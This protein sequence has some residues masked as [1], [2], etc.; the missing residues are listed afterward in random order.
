MT[1]WIALGALAVFACAL[2]RAITIQRINDLAAVR[3]EE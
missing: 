3:Q 1:T 2:Q